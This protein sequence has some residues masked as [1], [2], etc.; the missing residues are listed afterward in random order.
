MAIGEVA[1]STIS[2]AFASTQLNSS[3]R[4][5]QQEL[6]TSAVQAKAVGASSADAAQS[7]VAV[8]SSGELNTDSTEY[9]PRG[10]QIDIT[11]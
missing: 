9:A 4:S 11:V 6:Q 3:Q 5:A 10:S 1:G 8:A 2:T 7:V